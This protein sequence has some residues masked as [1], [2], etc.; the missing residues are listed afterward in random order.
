MT[1]TNSMKTAVAFDPTRHVDT[2]YVQVSCSGASGGV[3][4]TWGIKPCGEFALAR[5][6]TDPSQVEWVKMGVAP[7]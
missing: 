6:R 7:Q 4:Y 1:I 2:Q 5:L 3:K